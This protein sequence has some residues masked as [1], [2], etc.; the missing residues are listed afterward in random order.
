MTSDVTSESLNDT[1]DP[2]E[3]IDLLLRHLGTQAA[4][5]SASEARRRLEQYGPNEITR[6]RGAGHAAALA[7]QFTNP[8]ALLLWVAAG[9]ALLA[10]LGAL[11]VAIVTV[12]VL[13]AAFAFVQELQA[14]HATEALRE[15][16]P[17]RARVRR[18]GVE[19]EVDARE[20]VPGDVLVL[21][22]GDQLS[23][24]AR[25]FDGAIEV[26]MSPLTGEAQPV[27]RSATQRGR[28]ASPL[29]SEDLAFAGTL[30]TGAR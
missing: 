22:E 17:P 1:V 5:L 15:F 28:R 14:E 11:A 2:E 4:G 3:T 23:A 20:L 30:C 19:A 25:L 12:I 27:T 13:N 16:L 24:D 10:E 18:N 26:D 8:L 21:A 9:L 6:Q 7:A 29:E